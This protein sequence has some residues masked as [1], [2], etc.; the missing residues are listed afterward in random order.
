MANLQRVSKQ[1]IDFSERVANVGEATG[2]KRIR[3]GSKA[4]SHQVIGL[5]ER[6]SDV[7][8]AATGT[9]RSRNNLSD[10]MA[11]LGDRLSDLAAAAKGSRRRGV[12]G[13]TR[14]VLLPAAGAGLY[15]IA[16]SEFFA[17]QAKNVVD[18]AKTR[19]SELPND[20]MNSVRQTS[21]TQRSSSGSSS[22]RS[23][24]SPRRRK[25]TSAR[26]SRSTRTTRR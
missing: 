17:R 25:S 23:G 9:R 6:L 1:L 7:A 13:T 24:T 21:Q 18:E 19:A 12:A 22:S 14:W 4:L 2:Q 5:A 16:K 20:L 15:A 11:D 10:Q 8:D 3:N 26:K